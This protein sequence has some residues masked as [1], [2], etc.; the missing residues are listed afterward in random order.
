MAHATYE[1]VNLI[2][3]LYE[4]RR[5]EK[6]RAARDWFVRTCKPT[7]VEHLF[8]IAPPGSQENSYL[9]Q[10]ASYWEMVASFIV[11][12]VLNDDLF[13]QSGRELL[14]VWT[15]VEHLIPELR[16]RFK[17]PTQYR[18]LEIVAQRYIDWMKRYG[19]GSYDAFKARVSGS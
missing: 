13:F 8:E 5:E 12:G 6:M 18:N 11:T 9:R 16:E 10:V 14:L 17:D 1:D 19:P 3:R 15:R 4:M 2:L 7:S